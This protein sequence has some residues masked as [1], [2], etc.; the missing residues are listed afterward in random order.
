[1]ALETFEFLVFTFK[2]HKAILGYRRTK[3][4]ITLV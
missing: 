1:M 4:T 2:R 3:P